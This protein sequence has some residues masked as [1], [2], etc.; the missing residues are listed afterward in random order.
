MLEHLELT[1]DG[2][3]VVIEEAPR[4][5]QEVLP[6]HKLGG[7]ETLGVAA[8]VTEHLLLGDIHNEGLL[9]GGVEEGEL[10]GGGHR[11]GLFVPS[12]IGW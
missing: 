10:E 12:A 3:G 7:P 11:L 5:V 4:R 1:D 8:R 9:Q 2:Q 6:R